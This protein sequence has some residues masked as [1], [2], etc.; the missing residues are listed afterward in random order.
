MNRQ[1]LDVKMTENDA[2]P[3]KQEL[4][5]SSKRVKL[6]M[7]LFL[8]MTTRKIETLVSRPVLPNEVA[9]PHTNDLYPPGFLFND[10]PKTSV[11][12]IHIC[13]ACSSFQQHQISGYYRRNVFS[14][15]LKE[16]L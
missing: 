13:K 11:I 12:G 5:M 15:V 6:R 7:A 14:W 9:F 10:D 16:K 1:R 4:A 8:E 3:R 2:E